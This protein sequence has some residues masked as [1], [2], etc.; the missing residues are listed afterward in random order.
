MSEFQRQRYNLEYQISDLIKR[1]NNCSAHFEWQGKFK[2][3]GCSIQLNLVT[4]NPAHK[5]HFL[6]HSICR[7]VDCDINDEEETVYINILQ[8][9]LAYLQKR[10][11]SISKYM[12]EWNYR[13]SDQEKEERSKISYFDGFNIESILAKLYYGKDKDTITIYKIEMI[14]D[15]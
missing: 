15:S 9:M 3:P 14:P 2:G 11:K 6:L 1:D 5:S 4:F 12:V 10:Q 7:T 8:E 13:T